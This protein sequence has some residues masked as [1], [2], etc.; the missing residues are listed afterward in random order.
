MQ[1]L[2][3]VLI[4]SQLNHVCNRITWNQPSFLWRIDIISWSPIAVTLAVW[5]PD[6][7]GQTRS[8]SWPHDYWCHSP[9]YHQPTISNDTNGAKYERVVL[10]VSESRHSA[11]SGVAESYKCKYNLHFH[12]NQHG[13]IY[14]ASLLKPELN[15]GANASTDGWHYKA[16][17]LTGSKGNIFKRKINI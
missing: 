3:H 13:K 7:C 12:K 9:R 1:L 11:T 6:Y 8:I 16:L 4:S 17:L 10:L 14:I 5:D 2:I 15:I